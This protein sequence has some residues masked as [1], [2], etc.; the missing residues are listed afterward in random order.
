[1]T[2]EAAV[3]TVDSGFGVAGTVTAER[4]IR[5]SWP[6][7][8]REV[9]SRRQLVDSCMMGNCMMRNVWRNTRNTHTDTMRHSNMERRRRSMASRVCTE[10]TSRELYLHFQ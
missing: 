7:R 10:R 4:G 1:M 5:V 8:M 9:Q 3:V 2:L 6:G